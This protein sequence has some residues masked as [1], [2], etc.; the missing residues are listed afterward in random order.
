MPYSVALAFCCG[1]GWARL[2][3]VQSSSSIRQPTTTILFPCCTRAHEHNGGNGNFLAIARVEA[4]LSFFMHIQTSISGEWPPD[5]V[6]F[7]HSRPKQA[8]PKLVFEGRPWTSSKP[9]A[10]LRLI[11]GWA[12]STSYRMRISEDRQ[13]DR[14]V[15]AHVR[16]LS[17]PGGKSVT[18]KSRD[19]RKKKKKKQKPRAEEGKRQCCRC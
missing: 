5:R 11:L 1:C 12:L 16:F 4:S 6:K 8:L 2:R 14:H 7:W 15:C 13:T 17:P 10:L 3:C 9:R 18:S 19:G